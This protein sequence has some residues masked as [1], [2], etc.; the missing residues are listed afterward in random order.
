MNDIEPE[1]VIRILTAAIFTIAF[2]GIYRGWDT[3]WQ[4]VTKVG[5][6]QYVGYFLLLALTTAGT[7]YTIFNRPLAPLDWL[8]IARLVVASVVAFTSNWRLNEEEVPRRPM[9]RKHGEHER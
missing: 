2:Y 3:R 5:A 6:R 4:H 8:D 1:L 7:L 9:P